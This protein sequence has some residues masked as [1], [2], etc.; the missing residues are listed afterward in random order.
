MTR[1]TLGDRTNFVLRLPVKLHKR[2]VKAAR[3]EGVSKN[4]Y[5]ERVLEAAK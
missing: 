4:A 3:K 5:I 2:V 1:K